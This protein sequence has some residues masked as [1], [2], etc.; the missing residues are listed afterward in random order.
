MLEQYLE[1]GKI[2]KSHGVKGEVRVLPLT[3]DPER[4][5]LLEWVY[6]RKDSRLEKVYVESVKYSKGMVLLKL[7]GVDDMDA[8]DAMKNM[9]IVLDRANAVKLP[10]GSFFICDIIGCSVFENDKLLGVVADVLQTGSNDVYIVKDENGKEILVPAL[11]SVV[12]NIDIEGRRIEV[13]LP[14]GLTDL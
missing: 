12:S 6:I 7:K 14:K 4:F 9:F 1:I 3:D 13:I 2:T 11:K 10:E 5:S 8:A